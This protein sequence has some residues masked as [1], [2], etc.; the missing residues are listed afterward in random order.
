MAPTDESENPLTDDEKER[1]QKAIK[2]WIHS[3][4][5]QDCPY[6]E[7]EPLAMLSAIAGVAKPLKNLTPASYEDVQLFIQKLREGLKAIHDSRNDG[8]SHKPGQ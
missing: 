2:H 3:Q 1:I 8:K 6:T 7:K 4:L 5:D